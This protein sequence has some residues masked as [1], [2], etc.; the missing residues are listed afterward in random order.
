MKPISAK[1]IIRLAAVLL[2]L[3]AAYLLVFGS[4][5]LS[6]RSA[7]RN[8]PAVASLVHKLFVAVGQ[9][10]ATVKGEEKV[11]SVAGVTRVYIK[12]VNAKPEE[13]V[14]LEIAAV[15]KNDVL[16][17]SGSLLDGTACGRLQID[18]DLKSD[19]GRLLSHTLILANAGR[20]AE[21]SIRSRRRLQ[22]A[23]KQ[24]PVNWIV[25][26]AAIRCLDL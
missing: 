7:D 17:I 12:P 10:K 25:H 26:V 20:K 8:K 9:P 16:E 5:R 13:V 2:V 22:P 14:H 4:N 21:R 18:L 23:A 24:I 3:A 19:H 15:E 1:H 6:L 11:E